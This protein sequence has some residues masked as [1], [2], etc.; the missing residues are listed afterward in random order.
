MTFVPLEEYFNADRDRYY[1]NLQM[2]LPVN[3]YEGSHDPD[4]TLWILYFVKTMARAAIEL[5]RK[6][7]KTALSWLEEW[8]ETGFVDSVLTASGQ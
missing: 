1:Q 7:T 6:A 5:Q 2:G 4:H 8:L 3:F